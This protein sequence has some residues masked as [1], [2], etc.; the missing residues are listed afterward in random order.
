[1]PNEHTAN[2]ETTSPDSTSSHLIGTRLLAV[3]LALLDLVWY[4]AVVLAGTLV[5]LA[6]IPGPLAFGFELVAACAEFRDGLLC[7]QLL[8]RPLFDV[9]LLV[10]L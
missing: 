8:K 3:V 7:Q 9:L 4:D 2:N 6:L 5:N 10:F 1:M